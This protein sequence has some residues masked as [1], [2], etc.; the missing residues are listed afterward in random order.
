MEAVNI[1]VKHDLK[2]EEIRGIL[3]GALNHLIEPLHERGQVYDKAN[4]RVSKSESE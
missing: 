3:I 1:S 4:H 2:F